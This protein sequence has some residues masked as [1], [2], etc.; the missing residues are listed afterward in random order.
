MSM[1]GQSIRVLLPLVSVFILLVLIGACN[2]SDKVDPIAAEP[3]QQAD[4]LGL[5]EAGKLIIGT[6]PDYPP[7]E[8]RLQRDDISEIV[9]LDI[10]IAEAIAKELNLELVI[11]DYFFSKLFTALENKEVDM[12][13]AGLSPTEDRKQKMDF[14][15]VY[16]KAVQ[17]MVVR[18][19]DYEMFSNFDNLRDKHLGT[20]H[21]S[22]QAEMVKK[23]VRGAHFHEKTTVHELIEALKAGEL[24]AVMIEAP[25][26]EALA[27][28]D[29][30]L[31][32]IDIVR[33]EDIPELE[34]VDSAIAVRKGSQE[35][36]SRINEVLR[37]L[38][39]E[40][41]IETYAADAAALME[42]P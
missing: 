22:I 25:V 29:S 23:L 4:P 41:R 7:Y 21:G 1:R 24:D 8:F 19:V 27:F 10:A 14:S 34:M 42:L 38:I 5:V 26:A 2:K 32:L 30:N 20:Q 40:N 9:G 35:L 31:A 13:I 39:S 17:N 6:S 11:R 33:S 3:V 12:V 16:Y 37:K 28:K 18:K 36:L 15:E